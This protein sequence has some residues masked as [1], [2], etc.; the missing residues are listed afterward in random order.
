MKSVIFSGSLLAGDLFAQLYAFLLH[1]PTEINVVVLV[2]GSV[3]LL[4]SL[5]HFANTTFSAL[6]EHGDTFTV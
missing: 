3:G 2:G 1:S 4:C 6:T 5:R